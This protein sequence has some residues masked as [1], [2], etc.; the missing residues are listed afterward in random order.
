MD[1]ELFYYHSARM[2]VEKF[3]FRT[4]CEKPMYYVRESTRGVSDE[5]FDGKRR[6]IVMVRLRCDGLKKKN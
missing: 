4:V 5:S 6:C 3:Q 1:R 2:H